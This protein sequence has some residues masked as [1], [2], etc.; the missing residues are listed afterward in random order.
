VKIVAQA[1]G[2][3]VFSSP[4]VDS[5]RIERP[6]RPLHLRILPDI[7]QQ[8]RI[9][10]MEPPP[11]ASRPVQ[12]DRCSKFPDW[13]LGHAPRDL[14]RDRNASGEYPQPH[15]TGFQKPLFFGHKTRFYLSFNNPIS[16]QHMV[17]VIESRSRI[18]FRDVSNPP[19]RS[20]VA[21]ESQTERH[22]ARRQANRS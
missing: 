18:L 16:A 19:G 15:G 7:G 6:K 8:S 21:R 20:S 10:T 12:F 13:R 2:A 17:R 1:V 3:P 9:S 22:S 4:H 5:G 14:I 11:A